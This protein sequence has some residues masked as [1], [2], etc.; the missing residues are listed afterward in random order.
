MLAAAP[1]GGSAVI[2]F[3]VVK[4]Q[5]G[6]AIRLGDRM[7]T[8]FWSRDAAVREANCLAQAIRAHGQRT[9]VVI[10]G[11]QLCSAGAAIFLVEAAGALDQSA[12]NIDMPSVN[13]QQQNAV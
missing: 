11:G 12:G 7:S 10:Q 8:L 9:Q 1:I 2:T 3:N 5:Y 4:E 13:R 6:W